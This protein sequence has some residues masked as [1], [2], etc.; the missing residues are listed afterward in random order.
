[1][2]NLVSKIE[3]DCNTSVSFKC[4]RCDNIFCINLYYYIAN[5][6]KER[7][8]CNKQLITSQWY[9]VDVSIDPLEEHLYIRMFNDN[10][11]WN[12]FLTICREINPNIPASIFYNLYFNIKSKLRSKVEMLNSQELQSIFKDVEQW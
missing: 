7:C 4:L 11:N 9:N 8:H 12:K 1:M 2:K 3:Y 6:D 10:E 5:V